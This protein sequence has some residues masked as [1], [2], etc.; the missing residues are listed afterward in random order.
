M[1][2]ESLLAS[3]LGGQASQ[4]IMI[5]ISQVNF[6]LGSVNDILDHKLLESNNYVVKQEVFS[7]RKALQF[8][9]SMFAPSLLSQKATI[10]FHIMPF[11]KEPDV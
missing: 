3:T 9:E 2:L 1:F 4:M 7:I 5:L 11:M 8:V 6:L 10:S